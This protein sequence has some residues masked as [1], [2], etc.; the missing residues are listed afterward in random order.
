M[1]THPD[2][3]GPQT[4]L[5][6]ST[7]CQV[8]EGAF[9]HHTSIGENVKERTMGTQSDQLPPGSKITASKSK[10]TDPSDLSW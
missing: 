9:D 5:E 1:V 6:F 4:E 2:L 10:V 8:G 7:V 3:S